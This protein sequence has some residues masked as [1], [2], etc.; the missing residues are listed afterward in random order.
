M[1]RL[2]PDARCQSCGG[3]LVPPHIVEGFKL[4]DD[5]DYVCLRCRLA[6]RWTMDN[7]PQLTALGIES[8]GWK[9]DIART[10]WPNSSD[11]SSDGD[12]QRRVKYLTQLLDDLVLGKPISPS[13]PR[14]AATSVTPTGH[15]GPTV[16]WFHCQ[17]CNHVWARRRQPPRNHDGGNA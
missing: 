8:N 6:Y 17:L 10:N 9:R 15:G 14:C 4:P 1:T 5:A 12:D 3:E 13:C 11:D 2:L 16:E 7:P